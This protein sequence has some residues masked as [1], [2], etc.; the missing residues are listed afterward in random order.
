LAIPPWPPALAYFL[1]IIRDGSDE[2][3]L[4]IDVHAGPWTIFINS[5][6]AGVIRDVW[7][8]VALQAETAD[9]VAERIFLTRL[10]ILPKAE[11]RLSSSWIYVV[12]IESR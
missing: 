1:S 9:A 6:V 8:E 2:K 10:E 5:S 7:W 4:W 11:L 3:F 12:A